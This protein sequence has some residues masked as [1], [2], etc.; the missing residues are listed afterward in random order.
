MRPGPG[1]VYT[2]PYVWLVIPGSA[3]E[4]AGLMVGDTIL[5]IDGRDARYG[6]AFPVQVAGTRYV[7]LVR[8]GA[9]ELE[10][11]YVFPA[12]NDTPV[13]ERSTAAPPE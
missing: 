13:A 6:I 5:S 1:N 11:T 10:L 9:E 4:A 8:R 3:A 7:I 12:A 2:H